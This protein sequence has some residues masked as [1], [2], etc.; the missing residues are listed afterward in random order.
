MKRKFLY[1]ALAI[2]VVAFGGYQLLLRH[3]AEAAKAVD[4]HQFSATAFAAAQ[5]ADKRILVD[6]W[7]PWCPVCAEQ[8]PAIAAAQ[9]MPG[10]ADLVVFRLHYDDQKAEQKPF[11][12]TRQSTLIAYRGARETGRLIAATDPAEIADLIAS[13]R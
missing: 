8:Q 11:K 1:I 10:N 12:I 9:K 2:A 6:V 7:A 4:D 3:N 13:T 5:K